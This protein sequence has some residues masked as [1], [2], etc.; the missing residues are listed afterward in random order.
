MRYNP[1]LLGPC[2][3]KRESLM[4]VLK[5]TR[6]T[7]REHMHYKKGK[8]MSQHVKRTACS[9][10]PVPFRAWRPMLVLVLAALLA[11]LIAAYS[12]ASGTSATPTR[13]TDASPTAS[14]VN[15][16][17]LPV[18]T[19]TTYDYSFAMLTT[20]PARL[21]VMKLINAGSQP[22]QAS[23]GRVKPGV[24][25]AQVLAAAKRG[26]SAAPYLFSALDFA[27]GPGGISPHGQQETI[28][29]LRPGHYVALF[30]T[31]S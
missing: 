31:L 9:L 24:T 1:L 4:A 5:K 23:F 28:L 19:V 10:T 29:N 21:T 18:I 13:V 26:A 30:M 15:I 2:C 14:G 22:H 16:A 20:I 27:G 8:M 11:A 7:A 25:V 12:K 6:N 3:K 17:K